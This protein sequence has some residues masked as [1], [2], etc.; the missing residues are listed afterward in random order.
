MLP[1]QPREESAR[2]KEFSMRALHLRRFMKVG[3][4]VRALGFLTQTENRR[5]KP[6][7]RSRT[8]NSSSSGLFGQSSLNNRDSDRSANSFPPVWQFGQ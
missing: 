7:L 6:Y 1:K 3:F 4:H 2:G 5:P 8:N